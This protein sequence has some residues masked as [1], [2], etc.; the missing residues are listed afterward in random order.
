MSRY[1][2]IKRRYDKINRI[3]MFLTGVPSAIIIGLAIKLARGKISIFWTIP[4]CIFALYS[5]P[6]IFHNILKTVSPHYKALVNELRVIK[7]EIKSLRDAVNKI[8]IK[9]R[10]RNRGEQ[11][12]QAYDLTGKQIDECEERLA[13]GM[14]RERK[15]IWVT[16][17]IRNAEV[18]RVTAAIGSAFRCSP[19]DDPRYWK[20]HIERLGCDEL[21][22]YHNHPANNNRTAPSAIDYQT[23]YSLKQ[24]L[25]RHAKQLRSLI[26]YWNDIGEW[27]IIEHDQKD[28]Y[29]LIME[30]DA[31]NQI[32]LLR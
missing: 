9:Y 29:W 4:V 23:S 27:R 14:N 24:M 21:R 18:V 28:S 13:V 30:F 5:V 2:I 6:S 12:K 19:A 22:Q 32:N 15:E 8:Y 31:T 7:S 20:K 25:G 1:D 10:L 26:I 3:K 16:C 11:F 17:F